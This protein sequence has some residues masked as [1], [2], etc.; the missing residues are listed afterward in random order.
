MS[1]SDTRSVEFT[2]ARAVP[3]GDPGAYLTRPGFW[4]GA[5]GVAA[6]WL[7]GARAVAEPL[8]RRASDPHALAHLGAVDAALTLARGE[9]ID[10]FVWI[11]FE[12]VTRDNYK[13]F[14]NR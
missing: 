3:V 10:P 6:C 12:L 7:G 9:R 2:N 5:I 8:Y 14:L 4:H 11:P 1:G 13:S